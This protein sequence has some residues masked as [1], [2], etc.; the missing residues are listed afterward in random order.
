MSAAEG[1][2]K[3]RSKRGT[4]EIEAEFG[5]LTNPTVF[6]SEYLTYVMWAISPE[7]RLGEVLVVGN[8]R[9]KLTATTDLQAFALF[10]TAEPNFAVH[11]P[12]N[13]V[14]DDHAKPDQLY[15]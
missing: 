9:R 4:M 13:I 8:D 15:R 3:K 7:G 12:S 11:Q 14:P 10:V 5:N 1:T 6:G 2:A